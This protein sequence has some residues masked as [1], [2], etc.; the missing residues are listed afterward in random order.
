MFLMNF[1][2]RLRDGIKSLFGGRVGGDDAAKDDRE[3]RPPDTIY[4]MW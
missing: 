3:Q 2:R 1:F 4:P